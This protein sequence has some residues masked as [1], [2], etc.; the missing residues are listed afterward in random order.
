M[1]KPI[2]T[3]DKLCALIRKRH[4]LGLKKYGVT[5]DRTDLT[6]EQW[7]QH[8]IEEKIDDLKYMMRLKDEICMLRHRISSL[9][10]WKFQALLVESEWD[11]QKIATMLGARPGESCRKVIMREVPKMIELLTKGRMTKHEVKRYRESERRSRKH[12]KSTPLGMRKCGVQGQQTKR[13]AH[14]RRV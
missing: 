14:K 2:T 13:T 10:S 5:V 12:P 9:Q 8:S 1:K 6:A 4:K 3:T 7:L 11:P